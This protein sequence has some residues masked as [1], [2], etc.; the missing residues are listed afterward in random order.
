M[1]DVIVGVLGILETEG[2]VGVEGALGWSLGITVPVGSMRIMGM[3]GSRGMVRNWVMRGGMMWHVG[4][5]MVRDGSGGKGNGDGNHH[6]YHLE[7]GNNKSCAKTS[8]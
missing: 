3:V 2:E 4:R 6:G 1:R 5:G 8:L 7:N